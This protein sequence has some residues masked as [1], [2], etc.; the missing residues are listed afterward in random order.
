MA[1]LGCAG[2]TESPT[3]S[4]EPSTTTKAAVEITID[5]RS[6]SEKRECAKGDAADPLVCATR[7][8]LGLTLFY[9]ESRAAELGVTG[10]D[11]DTELSACAK[12]DCTQMLGAPKDS[13]YYCCY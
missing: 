7:A 13:G 2:R 10:L 12:L 1:A 3:S 11:C 6:D 8:C 4:P 5:Q 9:C